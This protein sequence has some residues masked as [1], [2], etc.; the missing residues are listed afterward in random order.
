MTTNVPNTRPN[1]GP[2][3][4]PLVDVTPTPI[5]APTSVG[6]VAVYDR[7]EGSTANSSLRPSA[8]IVEDRVPVETRSSMSMLTWIISA[9]V[10]I[11]LA[12]FLLQL[13]F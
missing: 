6:G 5:P 9:V 13:L 3:N 8:S 7:P 11:V 4:S 12:Y 10:L 2:V 1:S